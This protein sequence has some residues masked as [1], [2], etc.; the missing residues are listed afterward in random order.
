MNKPKNPRPIM[1]HIVPRLHL[2]RFAGA[3]PKGH[4]WTFSKK[5]A[6]PRSAIPEETAIERHFYSVENPDGTYDTWIEETLSKIEGVTEEPYR[7]LLVGEIPSASQRMDFSAFIATMYVR[8]RPARRMS[9]ELQSRMFQLRNAATASHEGA[10]DSFVRGMEKSEG[11]T[12]TADERAKIK[13][14]L[15]NPSSFEIHI[16]KERTLDIIAHAKSIMPYIHDMSWSVIEPER[17]FIITSDNPV[18]R[19]VLGPRPSMG[20]GGFIHKN[21]EV[22]FPLSPKRMLLMSWHKGLPPTFR[23]SREFIDARNILR[24]QYADSEIYSHLMHANTERLVGR[25]AKHRLDVAGGTIPGQKLMQTKV[26]RRWKWE[27]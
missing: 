25:Y 24:I 21:V 19:V 6:K 11:K 17:G 4:V 14:F 13:S 27:P 26:P 16:P 2:S 8:T 12:Y 5:G 22:S 7:K 9:A 15:L 1:Q 10:F 20:D 23:V 18:C 3:E